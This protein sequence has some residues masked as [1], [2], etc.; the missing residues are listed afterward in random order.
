MT[1]MIAIGRIL[2]PH[3]GHGEVKVLPLTDFPER[4]AKLTRVFLGDNEQCQVERTRWHKKCV[5]LKL[6]G[7]DDR[8]AAEQ[9]RGRLLFLPE[10]ELVLLPEGQYYVHQLIGMRV[11]T[12]AGQLLGI[13][14]DVLH[15]GANDVYVV[16]GAKG[17]EILVPAQRNVV[18]RIDLAARVMVVNPLPG[19][20]G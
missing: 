3:S 18:E 7:C 15:T 9:L 13:L 16:Q 5:L 17:Q 10:E 14:S 12:V 4:F 11:E 1:E 20:L 2:A 8:T 6:A 19:L